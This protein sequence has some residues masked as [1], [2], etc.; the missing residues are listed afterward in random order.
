M[1]N[2]VSAD[3]LRSNGF[4]HVSITGDTRIDRVIENKRNVQNDDILSHFKNGKKLL[5]LGSS[6]PE[7]EKLILPWIKE[8][9]LKVVIA[10]HDISETHIT[11]IGELLEK[12][13]Q[14][15]T[16]FDPSQE[17][18]VLILDT[19]GQLSN[20]YSYADIA[21]IGGGFSG[22]LHNI[23]E[24]AVFGVPVLFGPKHAKYPEA[25]NFINEGIAFEFNSTK[26]FQEKV[27]YILA[28][29]PY[30]KQKTE[31]FIESQSGA[32]A[33]IYFKITSS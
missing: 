5:V 21:Y 33:K 25:G 20:T 6:W 19:I 11:Q 1:Q 27:G 13:Y 12:S 24:P 18:D 8:S 17:S 7:G 23:L 22:S 14:R 16:T 32:A 30:Y 31:K 9:K 26:D 28:D 2:E 3:L 10:P 15:Y 4:K 29:L